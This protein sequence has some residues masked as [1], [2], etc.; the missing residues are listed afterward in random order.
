MLNRIE[1]IG[2]LGRDPEVRYLP[3]GAAVCNFTV[4]T[5]EKW[6]NKDT[7]EAMEETEWHRV[8]CFDKLADI[9]GQYLVKGSLV[10]VSGKLKSRK[11]TDKDGAE[12]TSV[13]ITCNEMKMLGG[14]PQQDGQQQAPQQRQAAPQ[15]NRQ[16]PQGQQRQA[17]QQGYQQQPQRQAAQ[18]QPQRQAAPRQGGGGFEDMDDDIPFANALRGSARCLAM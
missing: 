5:T 10:Y 17:P 14:R 2:H 12:K 13:E 3:S 11:Y 8:S 16:Q 15:Q 9:C 1:I 18:Q 7:G 4:A 6:K